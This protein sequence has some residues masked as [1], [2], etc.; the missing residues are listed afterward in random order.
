MKNKFLLLLTLMY[1]VNI[2]A[3]DTTFVK[4]PVTFVTEVFKSTTSDET[5]EKTFALVDGKKYNSNSVSAK[6]YALYSYNKK[7]ALVAIITSKNGKYK[8]VI[9]L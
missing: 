1:C 4:G 5:Y 7:E 6:R 8:K 9:V 2:N 3:Q